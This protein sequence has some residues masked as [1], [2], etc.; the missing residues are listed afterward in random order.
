MSENPDLVRSIYADWEDGDFSS[1]AWADPG[2]E[3]LLPDAPEG[4]GT[5]TGRAGMAQAHRSFLSA[6]D[7][8]QLVAD[9]YLAD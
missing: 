3:Y 2:I 4:G 5:W 9:D 6:W 8:W 7:G 1:A